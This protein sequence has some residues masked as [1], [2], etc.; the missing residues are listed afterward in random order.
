MRRSEGGRSAKGLSENKSAEG[1]E[2]SEALKLEEKE[3][4]G[5]G[6]RS[7]RDRCVCVCV[8]VLRRT[9][10]DGE[11]VPSG[12]ERRQRPAVGHREKG[13]HDSLLFFFVYLGIVCVCCGGLV[14]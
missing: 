5:E 7:D 10:A 8:L 4:V 3:R 1:E 9:R 6:A 13:S 2:K 14:R 12:H 11:H